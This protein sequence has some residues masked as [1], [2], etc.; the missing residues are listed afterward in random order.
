MN[1]TYIDD[2]QPTENWMKHESEFSVNWK[3]R[4]FGMLKG[5]NFGGII[6]EIFSIGF[7]DDLH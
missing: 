3:D 4:I 2:F 5:P 7:F 6:T 1:Y